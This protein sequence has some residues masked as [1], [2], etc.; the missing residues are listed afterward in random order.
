QECEG[1]ERRHP[2]DSRSHGPSSNGITRL[3]S[4]GVHWFYYVIASSHETASK[5][6]SWQLHFRSVRIQCAAV[7]PVKMRPY[8]DNLRSTYGA[9]DTTAPG[10]RTSRPCTNHARN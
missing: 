5:P 10:G 9:I 4:F 6:T 2:W 3:C 8:M 1:I 7:L